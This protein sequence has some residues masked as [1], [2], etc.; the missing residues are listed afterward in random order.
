[1]SDPFQ[2]QVARLALRAAS[3]HGF[4]LGG[5]HALIAYGIVSRPTEEGDLFTDED[6]GVQAAAKLVK[7]A[8]VDAGMA[9]DVIPETSELGELF[10]GFD[11]DMVEFEVHQGEHA[12]RLQLVRFDRR[13]SPLM[14]EIGPV[15]HIDDVVGSKVA[16]MATRAEPRDFIDVAAVLGSRSPQRLGALALQAGQ[17]EAP[18]LGHRDTTKPQRWVCRRKRLHDALAGDRHER[19]NLCRLHAVHRPR[20]GQQQ[21]P[22]PIRGQLPQAR[23]V[24]DDRQEIGHGP[25]RG[26]NLHCR[27][28]RSGGQPTIG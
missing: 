5:G 7:A 28:L 15:L 22:P 20:S 3:R 9:I 24:G 26:P 18:A 27:V 21:A 13:R 1:M 6:D 19:M 10:Y 8:L 25:K 23:C 11:R 17:H 16:A 2:T 14:M 12:V 4:A